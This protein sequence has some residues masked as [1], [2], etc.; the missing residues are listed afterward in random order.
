M[1]PNASPSITALP[2][3]IVDYLAERTVDAT[4]TV[5]RWLYTPED[6]TVLALNSTVRAD[7][8]N[9]ETT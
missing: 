2:H 9:K 8:D 4:F 6:L 5:L 7:S 1:H 3:R